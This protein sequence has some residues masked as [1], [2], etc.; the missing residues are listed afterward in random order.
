MV[1]HRTFSAG[2]IQVTVINLAIITFLATAIVWF[3][4]WWGRWTRL[5]R[6]GFCSRSRWGCSFR[7]GWDHSCH[8]RLGRWSSSSMWWV[9]RWG[10]LNRIRGWSLPRRCTLVLF[11]QMAQKTFL[12]SKSL[13]AYLTSR[14][15]WRIAISYWICNILFFKSIGTLASHNSYLGRYLRTA[16]RWPLRVTSHEPAFLEEHRRLYGYTNLLIMSNFECF[17]N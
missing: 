8:I 10:E 9:A 12:D 13:E 11:S 4:L 5:R 14:E 6:R 15:G 2:N 17:L 3:R 16:Q 1:I 7:L